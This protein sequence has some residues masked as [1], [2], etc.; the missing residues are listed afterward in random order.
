MRRW[1]LLFAIAAAV[2][3]ASA[4]HRMRPDNPPAPQ[5]STAAMP[6]RSPKLTRSAPGEFPTSLHQSTMPRPPDPSTA[7]PQPWIKAQAIDLLGSNGELFAQLGS[8]TEGSALWLFARGKRAGVQAGVHA[9]GYPFL[10]VSDGDVRDFGLG[11]VDGP[12]ASPILVFRKD[13]IVKM[14]FGLHL[15]DAGQPPFLVTY[16][17]AGKKTDVIGRY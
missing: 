7:A 16:S 12:N 1:R 17:A 10:L 5:R 9:N 4:L 8:T 2:G 6:S 11:R 15:S 13:D 3:V 14:V